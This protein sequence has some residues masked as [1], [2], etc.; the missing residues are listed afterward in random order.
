MEEKNPLIEH[1]DYMQ[2]L[3]EELLELNSLLVS[4][5]PRELIDLI[6]TIHECGYEWDESKKYFY[7]KEINNAIRTQGLDLFNVEKFKKN[8][9]FWKKRNTDPEYIKFMDLAGKVRKVLY[10]IILF[11]LLGWIVIPFKTWITLLT[12][13][14]IL[15]FIFDVVI[16]EKKRKKRD[17]SLKSIKQ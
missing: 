11:G 5:N 6:N 13:M 8:H 14:I 15:Y 9:E 16:L 2:K 17:E 10:F 3:M 12:V 1:H 4:K 7:N